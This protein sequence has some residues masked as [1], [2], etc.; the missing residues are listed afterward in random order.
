[1]LLCIADQFHRCFGCD[2][3]T[4]GDTQAAVDAFGAD[5]AQLIVKAQRF[6]IMT[7]ETAQ[8]ASLEKNGGADPRAVMQGHPLDVGDQKRHGYHS[9]YRYDNMF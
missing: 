4:G 3:G 5:M 2:F 9:F 8:G 6:R 7:P 1:M